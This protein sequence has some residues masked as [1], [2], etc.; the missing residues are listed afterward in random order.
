MDVEDDGRG[1]K[2]E[3]SLYNINFFAFY[4]WLVQIHIIMAFFMSTPGHV[5][6]VGKNKITSNR[7]VD[8]TINSECPSHP[9]KFFLCLW[10]HFFFFLKTDFFF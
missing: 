2:V 9:G 7:L 6:A 1:W 5:G 4:F 8:F 3:E 10:S